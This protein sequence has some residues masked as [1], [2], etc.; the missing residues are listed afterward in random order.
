M[1]EQC[2]RRLKLIG[3]LNEARKM[4]FGIFFRSELFTVPFLTLIKYFFTWKHLAI[5]DR[6]IREISVLIQ[7][8]SVLI[9][10]WF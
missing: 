1:L 10:D 8:I 7:E 5:Q 9:R 6:K 2:K 4:S 3:L